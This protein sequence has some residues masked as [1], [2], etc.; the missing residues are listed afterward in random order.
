MAVDATQL[1]YQLGLRINRGLTAR[2][3]NPRTMRIFDFD[4]RALLGS[5]FLENFG[6]GDST[7]MRVAENV[8]RH[9]AGLVS[10]ITRHA[11]VNTV[12]MLSRHAVTLCF[13]SSSLF[14]T[15]TAILTS[16][17]RSNEISQNRFRSKFMPHRSGAII[18]RSNPLRRKSRQ[19]QYGL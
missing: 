4:R 9:L 16:N 14:D 6:D 12:I 5:V 15:S 18:M 17:S 1:S 19:L 7:G 8:F 2:A 10:G 3:G 11:R 13:A